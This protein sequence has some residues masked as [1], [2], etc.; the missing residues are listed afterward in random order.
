VVVTASGEVVVGAGNAVVLVT[1]VVEG[2]VK[3]HVPKQFP[4]QFSLT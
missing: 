4:S 1:A 2:V 3:I